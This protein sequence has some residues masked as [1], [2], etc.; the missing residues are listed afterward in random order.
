MSRKRERTAGQ[1]GEPIEKT[2]QT[3]YN[4]EVRS[5]VRV[6][7]ASRKS[8]T[9]GVDRDGVVV[10]RAPRGTD[11]VHI[12]REI[13]R[14]R[15]WIGRRKRESAR[16]SLDLS[17]GASV[18]LFERQ[19]TI[20]CGTRAYRKDGVIYLPAE[21]REQSFVSVLKRLAREVMSGLAK[22]LAERY[23]FSYTGIYI[24]SAR[25]RWGSC[26]SSGNLSFSF[27]TAFLTMREARYVAA[28]E[29]C[30][31]RHMDHSPAFWDEVGKIVPEYPL[32][33]KGMRAKGAVMKWL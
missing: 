6:V 13:V 22:S 25:G 18:T 9:I 31:T 17:D 11:R 26:S 12:D 27:R 7:F 2:V 29:L 33:R 4:A 23:G 19:Y 10:V 3:W 24:T 15:R 21:H 16:F 14:H 20:A 32:I 28:H 30:H 8:L 5:D 1:K